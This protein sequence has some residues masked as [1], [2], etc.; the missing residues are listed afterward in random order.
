LKWIQ[1]FLFYHKEKR[2]E[3]VHPQE[4]DSAEVSGYLEYLAEERKVSRHS[5]AKHLLE[6]G[7]NIRA[8]QQPLGHA[9]VEPAPPCRFTGRNKSLAG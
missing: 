7:K 3:W 8:I 4:L 1:N 2:G 6:N 5:F 9:D